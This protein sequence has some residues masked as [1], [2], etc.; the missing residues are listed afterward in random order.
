M[1]K[2][3]TKSLEIID[4]NMAKYNHAMN[5]DQSS[6]NLFSNTFMEM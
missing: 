3:N 2:D 5:I 1:N 4:E 6:K